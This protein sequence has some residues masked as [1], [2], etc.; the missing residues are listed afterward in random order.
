MLMEVGFWWKS[1]RKIFP[2]IRK[3][4]ERKWNAKAEE[5]M[6]ERSVW[7]ERDGEKDRARGRKL[8]SKWITSKSNDEDERCA[9]DDSND[10]IKNNAWIF[11]VHFKCDSCGIISIIRK[12]FTKPFILTVLV[13]VMIKINDNDLSSVFVSF[14]PNIPRYSTMGEWISRL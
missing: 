3:Q 11:S 5:V 13:C 9:T 7:V 2:Q 6:N 10:D 8:K 14:F 1:K 4:K 12:Y